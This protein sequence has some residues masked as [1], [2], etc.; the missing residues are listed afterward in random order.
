MS[1]AVLVAAPF[2]PPIAF[3]SSNRFLV[4]IAEDGRLGRL[5]PLYFVLAAAAAGARLARR[6]AGRPVR[7]LPAAIALPAAAF[8]AFAF[9]SLLWADDVEAGDQPARVLHAARSWRCWRRSRAPTSPTRCRARWP[10]SR[11]A[12]ATLFAVVGLY[13]VAT[14]KLFFYAPNLAVSNANTDYFRV[15]SLFGD[16]SLYGRHVVLGHRRRA[17]RCS[18]PP[19]GAPGR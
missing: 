15:T 11:L 6:C 17:R 4:S 5:L 14:H 12:L 8:F 7:A 13:Q 19:A 2:R 10:P 9:L 3:D 1:I 18:P 16:P